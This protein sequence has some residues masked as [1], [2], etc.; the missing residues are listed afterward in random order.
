[1][2]R[3]A[4]SSSACNTGSVE[5]GLTPSLEGEFGFFAVHADSGFDGLGGTDFALAHGFDRVADT[6]EK[7]RCALREAFGSP[8]GIL[9]RS[10]DA[11]DFFAAGLEE[12]LAELGGFVH[13]AKGRDGSEF[14]DAGGEE[15]RAGDLLAGGAVEKLVGR[16]E[17][18]GMGSW[19]GL[20]Q[21][22]RW[23]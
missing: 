7:L 10:S 12:R 15:L 22:S 19:A 18:V 11:L 20:R 23:K 5:N 1:M 2:A 21:Q 3:A 4:A 17:P 14:A 6:A 8:N 9:H 16:M 13:G